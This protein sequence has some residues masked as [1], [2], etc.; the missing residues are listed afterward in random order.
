MG[1]SAAAA[2]A[3]TGRD[4][5]G[6]LEPAALAEAERAGGIERGALAVDWSVEARE[7]GCATVSIAATPRQHVESRLETAAAGIMLSA[8]DGVPLLSKIPWFGWPL[9]HTA[10]RDAR[11]ELV[12]FITP[13]VVGPG[14]TASKSGLADDELGSG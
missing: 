1:A 2:A 11:S 7:D 12:V 3:A 10:K 13:H 9:R 4:P 8:I 5:R 14:E 6:L